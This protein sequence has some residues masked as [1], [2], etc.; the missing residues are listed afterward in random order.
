MIGSRIVIILLLFAAPAGAQQLPSVG[1]AQ[2]EAAT[3]RA[4]EEQ[5]S[6]RGRA[7]WTR[8]DLA[9]ARH[10]VGQPVPD[11]P[12]DSAEPLPDD[13]SLPDA[14]PLR[15][16][17]VRV[18]LLSIA[19]RHSLLIVEN[20]Y[21]RAF[22]YRARMTEAGRTR[23]TDVCLVLPKQRGFEHW[24][25]PIERIELYEATLVGWQPGDPQPCR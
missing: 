8:H 5:A 6:G 11:A 9:V 10:L 18:R 19:G 15:P 16:D 13:G 1:L 24:P 17:E 2:G 3:L 23:P 14:P 21:D 4:G 22:I 20:G 12:V 25:H 7:E